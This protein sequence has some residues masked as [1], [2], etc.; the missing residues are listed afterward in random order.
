[1]RRKKKH[2][3]NKPYISSFFFYL[4][5]VYERSKMVTKK[6]KE[7]DLSLEDRRRRKRK[8]LPSSDITP[9]SITTT[10]TSSSSSNLIREDTFDDGTR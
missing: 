4:D 10:M 2:G 3:Q 1:V 5:G 6:S 8:I 7:S 9:T